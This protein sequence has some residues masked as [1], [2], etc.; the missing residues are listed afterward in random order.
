MATATSRVTDQ[1]EAMGRQAAQQDYSKRI[2]RV[3]RSKWSGW[4]EDVG[5]FVFE[6]PV[7]TMLFGVGV[8]L[9]IGA[10]IVRR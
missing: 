5:D 7:R 10:A 9:L 6:Q 4:A 8:G 3:Y 2:R 1:F